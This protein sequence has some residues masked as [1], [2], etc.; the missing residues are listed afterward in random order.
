[1][2]REL[3]TLSLALFVASP[4]LAEEKPKHDDKHEHKH[5]DKKKDDDSKSVDIKV[6]ELPAKVAAAF[7]K[8]YPDATITK[9]EKETYKDGQVHYEI[10]YKD[11]DGKE[12]DVEFDAEGE[13]L[14]D[15]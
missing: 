7:K 6:E 1:M 4:V 5:D 8:L 14:P 11:T 9:A 2:K 13:K 10:E 15:H 12:H 3:L